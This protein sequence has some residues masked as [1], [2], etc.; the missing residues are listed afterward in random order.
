MRNPE[1]DDEKYLPLESNTSSRK[2]DPE[3][4]IENPEGA[5]READRQNKDLPE[6]QTFHDAEKKSQD[7]DHG[8]PVAEPF[9]SECGQDGA[10]QNRP[11]VPRFFPADGTQRTGGAAPEKQEKPQD[12]EEGGK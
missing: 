8:D 6:F 7:E 3:K 10:R 4:R 9:D 12:P 5:E 11:G 1:A 2:D